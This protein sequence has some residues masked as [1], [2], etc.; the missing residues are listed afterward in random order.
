MTAQ[1]NF[2]AE[3]SGMFTAAAGSNIYIVVRPTTS[4]SV[5]LPSAYVA[6]YLSGSTVSQVGAG[7]A[8]LDLAVTACQQDV[9]TR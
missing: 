4:G 5:S 1:L 9:A 6:L 7:F 8:T 2:F 3:T